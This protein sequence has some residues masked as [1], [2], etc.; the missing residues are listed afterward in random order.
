VKSVSF[1]PGTLTQVTLTNEDGD[2]VTFTTKD[3]SIDRNTAVGGSGVSISVVSHGVSIPKVFEAHEAPGGNPR[4]KR[5]VVK[6]G[7]TNRRQFN[8]E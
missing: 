1:P 7:A 2:G 5:C 3:L 8:F 4:L 6:R